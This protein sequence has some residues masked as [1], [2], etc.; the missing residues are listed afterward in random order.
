[1]A[2][3]YVDRITLQRRPP[4]YTFCALLAPKLL[5]W[6]ACYLVVGADVQQD[7]EALL[8]VHPSTRGVQ[9]Q[10]AHRDAHAVA[11]QVSQAQ[12]AFSIS[13]YHGLKNTAG[14]INQ[15]QCLL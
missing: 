11:A 15:G 1:M 9:G 5:A 7:W 4:T 2:H 6:T 10:L 14:A 8:W 13:H 12:Y 3:C